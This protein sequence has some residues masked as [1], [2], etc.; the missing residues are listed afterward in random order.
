M[1]NLEDFCDIVAEVIEKHGNSTPV[2]PRLGV[3]EKYFELPMGEQARA[4]DFI[5]DQIFGWVSDAEYGKAFVALT[6]K[7]RIAA[8]SSAP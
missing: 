3:I 2:P 6:I 7:D 8:K 5:N 1:E 4:L